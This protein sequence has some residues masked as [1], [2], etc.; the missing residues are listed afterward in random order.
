LATCRIAQPPAKQAPFSGCGSDQPEQHFYSGGLA[1]AIGTKESENLAALNR[2]AEV[3][4]GN[5]VAEDLAQVADFKGGRGSWL[6][7]LSEFPISNA[8]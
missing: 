8:V 3:G 5:L 7:Y 2:Q 6:F 4:D 1:G